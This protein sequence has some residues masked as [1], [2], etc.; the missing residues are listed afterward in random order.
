M[1]SEGRGHKFESCRARYLSQQNQRLFGYLDRARRFVEPYSPER[2]QLMDC[3]GE[4]GHALEDGM[5]SYRPSPS[6][7]FS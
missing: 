5:R 7:E 4:A 2:E 3:R 6:R 1:S